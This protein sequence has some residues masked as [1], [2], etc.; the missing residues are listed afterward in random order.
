MYWSKKKEHRDDI[1][2]GSIVRPV[3]LPG[4]YLFVDTSIYYRLDTSFVCKHLEGLRGVDFFYVY[5]FEISDKYKEFTCAMN[6][7]R[8][9]VVDSECNEERSDK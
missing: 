2:F 1:T 8:D 7:L 5:Y 6:L 9:I 3:G 4:I